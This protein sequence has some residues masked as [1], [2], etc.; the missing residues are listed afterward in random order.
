MFLK[1]ILSLLLINSTNGFYQIENEPFLTLEKDKDNILKSV[2]VP[3]RIN[4]ENV[5]V[6]ITADKYLVLDV[7]SGK[8]LA[9]K[10]SNI[11][12][13]IA[14]ITKIMTA[15]V[16]LDQNPNWQQK[17]FLTAADETVGASP[18]IY[19]GEEVR[20]IDL[21]KSGLI[22]S[23]NNSIMA[24][25]RV[26]GLSREEFVQLMNLKAKQL[27]LYNSHFSDPTGLDVGNT[28]T[29]TDVARLIYL[30]MKNDD[31]RE[32]VI[33]ESYSFKILNSKKTRKVTN[34]DILISSFLNNERYGYKLIG[35]KTGFLNE[36]GYCLAVEVS[37]EDK[38]VIIVV[39]NSDDINARFQDT[40]VLADWVFNNYQW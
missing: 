1:I 32:T 28:S 38:P 5:G 21:W 22:A 16:I 37:H 8:V 13:P 23:D 7:S 10:N 6:K 26:L 34:T 31:I 35:G 17:V 3:K 29:A 4:L 14:S 24:M 2:I 18:H 27:G 33:Q 20:F 15:L 39:L 12:Q 25:V 9:E 11:E 40:K 30:A 36:A 19:R